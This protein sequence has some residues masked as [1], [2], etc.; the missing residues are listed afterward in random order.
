MINL[1]S[2]IRSRGITLKS[3]SGK[4]YGTC[5]F[6]K[7]TEPS[8]LLVKGDTFSC[9]CCDKS[10]DAADFLSFFDGISRSHALELLKEGEVAL[11]K[12]QSKTKRS[13]VL[14]L[15][16][17]LDVEAFDEELIRQ[18][19]DFYNDHLMGDQKTL[20]WL[21]DKG[22]TDIDLLKQ[23]RVGM[24]DRSLGLRLPQKNR[25]SG[26][27]LRSRLVDLGLFKDTGFGTFNGCLV[28][29]LFDEDGAITQ[30]Y[31]YKK[32]IQSRDSIREVFLHENQGIFNA[33]AFNN[34]NI[35][36]TDSVLSALALIQSGFENIVVAFSEDEFL[37]AV[38]NHK[39]DSVHIAFTSSR[40][41][42]TDAL[43]MSQKLKGIGV[44]VYQAR[45]PW[46]M[47]ARSYTKKYGSD[48][49]QEIM[50]DAIWLGGG[51]SSSDAV[52][53]SP[54]LI[55]NGEYLIMETDG[56]EYRVGG[57]HKNNSMEVMRI[58]LRVTHDSLMHV[59]SI[60]LY[61][62]NDRNRFMK[63]A[64]EEVLLD[65]AL[66]KRDLGKL[67]LL[68]EQ[69]QEERL[70]KPEPKE[71]P[72]EG[73]SDE[74][75]KAAVA[76]LKAPDLLDR[77]VEAYDSIGLIGER[78]NKLTAYLACVSRLFP[79]PLA[80]CIQSASAAGKSALMDSVL[81]FFDEKLNYSAITGQS[82][83]YQGDLKHKILAISEDIGFERA[84]GS[85]KLLQ[86]QGNLSISS[87]SKDPAS[88]RMLSMDYTVEGPISLLFS[89]TSVTLDEEL[90]NRCLVLTIN[91]TESQTRKIH[92]LQRFNRTIEGILAKQ[93]KQ[94]V[95]KL[96][97]NVEKL[98]KPMT[99]VNPYANELTFK[100]TTTRTRRDHEKYLTLIDS[101]CLLRQ[102]QKTVKEYEG[103]K[104]IEVSQD[105]IK[106]AD[107]L[108]ET[109]F[110]RSLDEL[111]PQTRNMF[112]QIQTMVSGKQ[113]FFTRRELRSYTGWSDHQVRTHL[114]R[115]ESMEY[116]H[117]E[118]GRQGKQCHYSVIP[119]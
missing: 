1:V 30:V 13:T 40:D 34:R 32:N 92:D 108:A 75:Q 119:A 36:L 62:S 39:T 2:I 9:K 84:S 110:N 88:G 72:K 68:L 26:A 112:D 104:Y 15:P 67:L 53:T 47:D 117:R 3:S 58:T 102:H 111:P 103:V 113:R 116:I 52:Q 109:V 33:C 118:K 37:D 43:K 82:L 24:A 87:T 76:F 18:V 46:G 105:D 96:M 73:M 17:P 19:F 107:F 48:K 98:L 79:K 20:K 5:P 61:K 10:G 44:Q 14:K 38:T 114:T 54:A 74:E 49:L 71:E 89:T 86:S 35:V 85:L 64:K 12:P 69:H 66:L 25:N 91:E 80:V 51:S 7:N 100:A 42:E 28:F 27:E 95:I 21:S 81:E 106:D 57:L 45:F 93:R 77:I 11:V 59:D 6:H 4:F 115:L 83:F 60:D 97:R 90:M 55:Q 65:T 63:V 23:F 94:E 101:I 56:I 78:T 8:S 99:V 50:D 41:G 22:I 70:A 29:P 31:G 16:C